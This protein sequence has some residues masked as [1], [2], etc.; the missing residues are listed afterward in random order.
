MSDLRPKFWADIEEMAKN[1]PQICVLTGDLGYPWIK[2]FAQNCPD[3]FINCGAA[4]QNMVGVAAG[5]ALGGKKP[6]IYTGTAF[7]LRCYEQIR[8]DICYNNLPVTVVST[9]ASQFLGFSHNLTEE[10]MSGLFK[11]FPEFK[12]MRL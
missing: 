8:D 7:L 10:E 4:E 1:D 11:G 3:Q 6:Y 2:T 9:G 5:L 12:W